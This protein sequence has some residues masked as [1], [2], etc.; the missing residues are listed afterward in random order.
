M[1]LNK[2]E[3]KFL[4]FDCCVVALTNYIPYT[5][6]ISSHS[7][8][9]SRM[10]EKV[11]FNFHVCNN[12]SL[13]DHSLQSARKA[14]LKI[15]AWRLVI[16]QQLSKLQLTVRDYDCYERQRRFD[17]WKWKRNCIG[18]IGL[19]SMDELQL[20]NIDNVMKMVMISIEFKV[21]KPM[22]TKF[23]R[24]YLLIYIYN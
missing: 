23:Y 18:K 4:W 15:S 10:Q 5:N 11:F 7:G 24:K 12:N 17:V 16:A 22:K 19:N 9:I 14:T 3:W 8:E 2:M 21:K 13:D 20:F 6:R 1:R